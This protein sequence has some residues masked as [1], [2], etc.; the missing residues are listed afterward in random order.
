MLFF[1]EIKK[2]F[3]IENHVVSFPIKNNIYT[4][5]KNIKFI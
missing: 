2:V 1:K 5:S 4:L 3:L